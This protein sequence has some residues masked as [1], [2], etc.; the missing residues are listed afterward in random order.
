MR[1]EF[2]WIFVLFVLLIQ[3]CSNSDEKQVLEEDT[4]RTK[5]TE[6]SD[7]LKEQIPRHL[8][9]EI[10]KKKYYIDSLPKEY[11]NTLG[12]KR[13]HFLK[14]Y[15]DYQI[16]L[17]SL[18]KEQKTYANKIEKNR[19]KVFDLLVKKGDN[20]SELN[21]VLL[22]K[23]IA[24]DTISIELLGQEDANISKK[25]EAFY[26][27][28]KELYN[29]PDTLEISAI[30]SKEKE[31]LKALVDKLKKDKV[32]LKRFSSF[33]S[34]YASNPKL[35]RDGG[36]IGKISSKSANPKLFKILWDANISKGFLDKILSLDGS[37]AVVYI[38]NK[39]KAFVQPL[40]KEREEIKKYLLTPKIAKWFKNRI[41]EIMKKRE[42]KIY[43]DFKD[44]ASSATQY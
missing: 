30:T 4:N 3:S 14:S 11:V 23:K 41:R 32:D 6:L 27:K 18:T 31:E 19:K 13:F 44:K 33:A 42:V 34:R 24:I 8:L 20:M 37:Y 40:E 12:E 43:D 28:K 29:Y 35:K 22:L 38:H 1:L 2:K 9:Y 5:K 39:E 17:E 15:I 7:E 10:D 25:V 36:Y 21:R 16:V 26:N